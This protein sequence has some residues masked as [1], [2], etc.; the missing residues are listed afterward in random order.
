M[1][2]TT[3]TGTLRSSL[4]RNSWRRRVVGPPYLEALH[5]GRGRAERRI[6]ENKATGLAKL[7]SR[8]FAINSAWLQFALTAHDLLAWTRLFALEGDLAQAEPKRLRYCLLHTAARIVT[9]GRQRYA[10]LSHDWPWTPQLVAA[11]ERV[12]NLL[13]L[14]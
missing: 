4:A 9:T 7:P 8:S 10:R 6:C 11:F 3:A 5:R 14:I 12:H 13:L 2:S 1:R